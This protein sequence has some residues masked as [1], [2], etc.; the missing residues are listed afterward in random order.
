MKASAE[1]ILV[2]DGARAWIWVVLQVFLGQ[3]TIS[4]IYMRRNP[5]AAPMAAC[6][7]ALCNR[8]GGLAGLAK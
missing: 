3:L 1:A 5:R 4:G 7:A 6:F 2:A 8:S